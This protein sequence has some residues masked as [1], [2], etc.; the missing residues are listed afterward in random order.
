[1]GKKTNNLRIIGG[2]W[3]SRRIQFHNSPNIRPTPDRVRETLFNWLSDKVFNA[4]CLDLF[5]G[6]GALGFEAASR[7]ASDVVLVDIDAAVVACLEKQKKQLTASMIQ[8]I[9]KD[10]LMYLRQTEKCFDIIFLDPPFNTDLHHKALSIIIRRQLLTES[11]LIYVET[12]SHDNLQGLQG[13]NC[14]REKIAGQVRYA[15]YE[16]LNLSSQSKQ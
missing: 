6:S 8:I 12:S 2:E 14:F 13:F 10:A 7:G 5:A 3:R 16:M 4:C 1:M 11:G 9:H 15:L